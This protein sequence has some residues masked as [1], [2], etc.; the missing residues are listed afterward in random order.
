[1][2]IF[3][4]IIKILV[5]LMSIFLV[6]AVLMQEGKSYGLGAI[7]GGADNFFGKSKGKQVSSK[8][9]KLTSVIAIVF[10][11]VV[12]IL[13]TFSQRNGNFFEGLD[14][15]ETLTDPSFGKKTEEPTAVPT[16]T[17]TPEGTVTVTPS[18]TA[19]PTATAEAAE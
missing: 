2:G 6:V 19:T 3:S 14:P 8:L 15:D 10:V 4:V 9:S 17:V 13:G 11:V 12:I 7:E 5:L 18:A 1:M 16:V